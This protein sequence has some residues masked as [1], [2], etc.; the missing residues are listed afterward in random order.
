M[1][2]LLAQA[3]W[4]YGVLFMIIWLVIVTSDVLGVDVSA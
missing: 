3:H 1:I 4:L 2:D